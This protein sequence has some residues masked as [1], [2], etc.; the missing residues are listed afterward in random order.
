MITNTLLQARKDLSSSST[1]TEKE[2]EERGGENGLPGEQGGEGEEDE[3]FHTPEED[4]EKMAQ[5]TDPNAGK[6]L[7]KKSL[8]GRLLEK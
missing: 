1:E 6:T 7:V 2:T 5:S 8:C 4:P 3:G